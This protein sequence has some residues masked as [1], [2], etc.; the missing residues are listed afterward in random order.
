MGPTPLSRPEVRLFLTAMSILFVELL[1]IRWIP[2]NV[3]YIGFFRNFL[4]MAS[5]LGIGVGILWGRDPNRIQISPFGPLMLALVL[6]VTQFRVTIQLG[7]PSEIFF[8][9]RENTAA[10]INF[11]VLPAIV[12]ITTLIM[13]G[14]A[15]PLGRLLNAMPP[16]KAY[17]IDI[18]GSMTGVAMFT[19]LAA[20]GTPPV[21]WFTVVA[22]LVSLMGL[23]SG[24]GRR[25]IVTAGSLGAILLVLFTASPANQTWSPYYRIDEY[26]IGDVSFIDV[27]GIPHQ[28]MYPIDKK[29]DPYYEQVYRWFPDR[30]FER[31]LI[32]GAGSGND[33]AIALRHGASH[34][35]AVEIDPRIQEIGV[36]DHPNRPY[37]DPRVTR[38][39]DDGRAFLRRATEPYD[40]VVFALPDSLTLVSTSAN[41]RLE[42][43]LFTKEA[44]DDVRDRLT[45]DGIFVMY[46]FYREEW[47]PQKIAAMLQDS[48]GGAPIVR[49]YGGAAAT[50]AAGPA[51]LAL[52]G[53][54]PPGEG[55]DPIDLAGAPEP[56]TDDWPFLY[57]RER[58]IAPYYIG[59]LAII[60]VFAVLLVGRA[61]YRSGTSLRKFSPHFFVLG[62]AFLL[63]ETK[64][65]ATFSL[66]FGTTWIV[67]ALVFFAVLASVLASIAVNQR[68]RFRNP[69]LLYAGL[70]GTIGLAVLLPPSSL[71][72]EPVWLRYVVASALAFAPIFFA[73]LVFTLLV[74]GYESGGHGVCVEPARC[75]RRW[76]DRI[77]RAHQR[78]RLAARDRRGALC[79]RLD[80]RHAPADAGRSGPG[81]RPGPSRRGSGSA[82]GRRSRP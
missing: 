7:D 15:V 82:V 19:I 45:D 36:R 16:L 17:S 25:S 32:V 67:N 2:A 26:K 13:A 54:S 49:A 74:P 47:L 70:F 55:V 3:I 52:D 46:N 66:L 63:L 64:S 78:L 56:A 53:G 34:V 8:G 10:D 62:M 6:L 77:R 57:L 38:I 29:L 37:D 58:Y 5:F 81:S 40:L 24:L 68:L 75:R 28:A 60:I 33:V 23:A 30:T 21:V 72:I 48:F 4:L 44:F 20:A 22:I 41:L 42:S 71:L 31:V 27:N 11:L 35:D 51:V 9:L 14:L 50:L 61:A 76:G 12:I 65:L 69:A 39:V 43:F 18:L 59:A 73:N 80:A 79:D 1:L